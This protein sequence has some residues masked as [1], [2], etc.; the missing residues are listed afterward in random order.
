MVDIVPLNSSNATIIHILWRLRLWLISF[1][2]SALIHATADRTSIVKFVAGEYGL[3]AHKCLPVNN[4][5]PK[6]LY[7]ASLC[8]GW[9]VVVMEKIRNSVTLSSAITSR[10]KKKLEASLCCAVETLYS[11]NFVH[12]ALHPPNILAIEDDTIRILDFDWAGCVGVMK[13]PDDLN[14]SV[15]WNEDVKPGGLI[16]KKYNDYQIMQI[17]E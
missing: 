12:G 16:Q 2:C 14:T 6:V 15:A 13:Y 7:S 11:N 17:F 9:V 3:D 5:A 1:C 8:G 4:L 10:N